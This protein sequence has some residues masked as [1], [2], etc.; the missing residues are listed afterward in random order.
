MSNSENYFDNDHVTYNYYYTVEKY[1]EL[2]SFYS[3]CNLSLVNFN[4]RSFNTNS[5]SFNGVLCS[6]NKCPDFIV[7]SE[8]WNSF[9]NV[10]LCNIEGYRCRIFN[11]VTPIPL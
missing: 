1:K 3:L 2:E 5:D 7:L 4:I 9:M 11:K 10:D 8:T 6:M